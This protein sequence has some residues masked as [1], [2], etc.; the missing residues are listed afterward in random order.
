MKNFYNIEFFNTP[1]G[2]VMYHELDQPVKIFQETDRDIIEWLLDLISVRYPDAFS[3]LST[4]YSVNSRNRYYYEFRMARRFIRCNFGEF[5]QYHFDI[6]ARGQFCF[7]EVRCPLRGEC[8]HEGVICKPEINTNLSPR[9]MEVYRLIADGLQAQ[10]IAQALSLST[11]TVNRHRENIKAKIN[12]RSA[13][14][15]VAYWKNNNLK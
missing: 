9:E 3:A 11:Y 2:E 8:S 7:E 14:Q 5:D 13:A 1:T 15:M 12:V 6:D 4:L 10:E